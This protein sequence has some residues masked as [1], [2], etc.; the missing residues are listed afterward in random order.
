MPHPSPPALQSRR[1]GDETKDSTKNDCPSS[2]PW[3]S[4]N[5]YRGPYRLCAFVHQPS[6][7]VPAI[8]KT[9]AILLEQFNQ[10]RRGQSSTPRPY[11]RIVVLQRR[12]STGPR[13]AGRQIGQQPDGAAT[14]FY[15]R[16]RRMPPRVRILVTFERGALFAARSTRRGRA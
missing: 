10:V 9:R 11:A 7:Q 8:F 4:S 12:R 5:R 1:G 3:A 14:D 6:R 15:P 2:A 13:R 16:A